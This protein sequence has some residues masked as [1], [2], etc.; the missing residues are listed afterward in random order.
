MNK[1]V[2]TFYLWEGE[3]LDMWYHSSSE[4]RDAFRFML[5]FCV[6]IQVVDEKRN[7]HR[8]PDVTP[9]VIT[10]W[11]NGVTKE[12]SAIIDSPFVENMSNYL[13]NRLQLCKRSAEKEAAGET[14]RRQ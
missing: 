8:S 9:S 13:Q 5:A 7:M 10:E 11:I 6:L 1:L 12:A 2:K 3:F 14:V 4:E